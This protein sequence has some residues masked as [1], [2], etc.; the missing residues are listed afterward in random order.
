MTGLPD[1]CIIQVI[2]QLYIIRHAQSTN[3][4][5]IDQRD[6]VC[7]P[8]LTELGEQQAALV[9]QHLAGG[10]NLEL[11]MGVSEEATSSRIRRGYGLTRLYCSAMGRALKTA[12]PI[13]QATGLI[14]EVWVDIHEHGGIFLDHGEAGGLVGY[15]GKTRLEILAEFPNYILPES[16]TEQGWW[17]QGYEDRAACHARAMRVARQL[18]EWADSHE[19]IGLV[20]HGGFIDS[21]IKALLN[22]LPGRHIFYNHN[23]SAISRIDF[24]PDERLKLRYLNRIDHLPPELVT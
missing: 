7:D 23:N 10:I 5:L 22:Q 12:Q 3:N 24:G 2:M 19:R 15:P 6:R 13:S 21:L 17:N 16:I 14:P 4:A 9:A 1:R 11:S 18:Y 8:P 20:T